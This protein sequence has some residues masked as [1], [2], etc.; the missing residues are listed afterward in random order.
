MENSKQ[1]REFAEECDRL[2][3]EASTEEQRRVLTNLAAAWS[4]ITSLGLISFV[5]RGRAAVFRVLRQAHPD[6]RHMAH[7]SARF[8][9][10]Q[11]ARQLQTLCGVTPI[12]F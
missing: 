3:Q 9:L 7:Q 11:R 12:F 8:R 2:A 4:K 6:L 1:F 5:L 10:L